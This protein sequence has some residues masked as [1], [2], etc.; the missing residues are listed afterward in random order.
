M[1]SGLHGVD[2]SVLQTV[3]RFIPQS[4]V[5]IE[6]FN[7]QSIN[8]KS[9]LTEEHIKE[10]GFDFMCLTETWHQLEVYSA[11]NEACP[12]GYSYLEAA[13]SAG[14]G[15]GLAVIFRQG[16]KVTP[17]TLPVTSS[18]ECLAFKCKPPF[19]MTVLLIYRPPKQ[20]SAFIPEMS[21]DLTTLCTTS[22]N[23]IILGDI[24]IHADT[25]S[26]QPAAKFLQMLESLNLHQHVNVPT[27]SGEHTLDLVISNSAP[28]RNLQVYD[29]GLSDHKV[30]SMELPFPSPCTKPKQQIHFRK[31][32][33]INPDALALDF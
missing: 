14:R 6:L 7:A 4:L 24:H 23:T 22:T 8:N 33:N 28:I 12:L 26:R 21:D 27:H 13:R 9:T 20:N 31:L 19:P 15:G 16:L 3:Q 25:P 10:R 30:V 11:L 1:D 32:K 2:F 29:L 17:I 5:K 18:C